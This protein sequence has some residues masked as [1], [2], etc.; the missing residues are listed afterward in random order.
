MSC[1]DP[2][3]VRIHL[4]GAGGA[5][6]PI[7]DADDA[8]EQGNQVLMLAGGIRGTFAVRTLQDTVAIT[9]GPLS[10][11]QWTDLWIEELGPGVARGP[12]TGV[13]YYTAP[14]PLRQQIRNWLSIVATIGRTLWSPHRLDRASRIL[15][16]IFLGWALIAGLFAN[17][18]PL[19]IFAGTEI[20]IWFV[21]GRWAKAAEKKTSEAQI[22]AYQALLTRPQSPRS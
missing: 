16:G 9:A 15:L 2:A 22:A 10:G 5:P 18:L 14:A 4:Y 20:V 6:G 19:A 13:V 1:D 7:I 21:R 3:M 8:I 11:T 17:A 12:I